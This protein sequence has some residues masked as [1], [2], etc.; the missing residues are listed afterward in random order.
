MSDR[1]YIKAATK[2]E[3]FVEG[4]LDDSIKRAVKSRAVVGGLCMAI[5]LWGIETAV[6]AACLWG[7]YKKISSIS[8]V[9]FGENFIKNVL[10]GFIVN[11][12]VTF[13]LGLVL[14][15][16]PVA[17]WI[18]SFAVGYASLYLSAMGYVKA[19]KAFHGSRSKV[20]VNVSQ[21]LQFAQMNHSAYN[22]ALKASVEKGQQVQHIVENAVQ[23][24]QADDTEC[25]E[26]ETLV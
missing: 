18:G 13:L 23:Q 26:V 17:G 6:Y 4:A 3:Q 25:D 10:S 5:P 21:G 7:A 24:I 11:L 22:S 12:I 15:F 16:I 8:G 20:D 14:D 19:L 1:M 9:P 2:I